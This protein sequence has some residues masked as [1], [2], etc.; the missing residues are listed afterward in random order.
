M[1]NSN[2]A[3]KNADLTYQ[4]DGDTLRGY[5][6]WPDGKGPFTTLV[7][8]PDVRGLSEHYRDISRRFAA[9]GFL[10][11]AVDYYSRGGV[12]DLPD[13]DAVFRWIGQLPDRRVVG[14]IGAAVDFLAGHP[15]VRANAIGI[16]GY[17]LGGQYAF[18][19]AC[20]V[21]GLA[22]CV[23]W[24]GMLRYAETN[25]IKPTSPL[26]LA[27]QLGGAYLGLFGAE[28]GLIPPADV[29]ELWTVLNREKKTFQMQVYGGAGHAFFNDTRPDAYRPEQAKDSWERALK[30]FRRHLQ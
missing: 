26:D 17:C 2:M 30:F 12:P 15:D 18:M 25:E 10:T 21:Q 5:A 13:M 19:S 9:E 28:D 23:S 1:N 4:R 14:D 24:Y 16:T 7:L 27:S 3:Q 6:A 11:F 20:S 8:I 29:A 22:A